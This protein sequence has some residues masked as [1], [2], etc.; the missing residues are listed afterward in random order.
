LY[1]QRADGTGEVQRLTDST[2]N[3]WPGSWDPTGKLLAFTENN[4]Q[5]GFDVMILPMEGND[6]SGWH[7]GKATTFVSTPVDEQEPMF[8]PDGRWIAY[9]SRGELYVQPF[10]GPGG[11]WQVSSDGGTDAMWSRTRQELFYGTADGRIMVVAYT[12]A[13]ESFH[14]EKPRPWSDVRYG[15]RPGQRSFD[16]HPDGNRFVV[17]PDMASVKQDHVTFIFNFG[18]ELLRIAAATKR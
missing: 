17:R 6:A 16:L 2:N 9:Q 12:V 8:S 14:A 1:W 5:K 11:K 7:S 4:P 15:Q 18:D 13:G 3:Q 10:P